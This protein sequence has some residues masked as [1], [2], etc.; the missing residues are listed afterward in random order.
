MKPTDGYR[1]NRG[2]LLG[3]VIGLALALPFLF[4]PNALWFLVVFPAVG[5]PIGWIVAFLRM[6]GD[7]D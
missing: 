4:F 5:G 7:L 1:L 3:T 6:G 2:Y